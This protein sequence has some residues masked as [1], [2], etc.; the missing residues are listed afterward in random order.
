MADTSITMFFSYFVLLAHK[1]KRTWE[2]HGC[3]PARG[4]IRACMAHCVANVNRKGHLGK[5]SQTSGQSVRQKDSHL[6]AVSCPHFQ[7]YNVGGGGDHQHALIPVSTDIS[8][9]KKQ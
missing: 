4:L 9:T 5:N 6:P 7:F 8:D 3:V 1:M 2:I